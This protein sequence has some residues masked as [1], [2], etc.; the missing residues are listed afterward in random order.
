LRERVALIQTAESLWVLL[1]EF[2]RRHWL[3]AR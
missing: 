2:C 3:T 1:E